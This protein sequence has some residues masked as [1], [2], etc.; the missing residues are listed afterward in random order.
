MSRFVI[1]PEALAVLDEIFDYIADGR[2]DPARGIDT[3][4][5]DDDN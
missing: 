5:H 1:R 2:L 4:F 3:L